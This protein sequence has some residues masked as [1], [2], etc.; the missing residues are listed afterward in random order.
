MKRPR[1]VRVYLCGSMEGRTYEAVFYEHYYVRNQLISMGFE[2][3]DPLLKESHKPGAK[4][5]LTKCGLNP[6]IVY[7]QDLEA[8]EKASIIF[9]VT[10][11]LPTEGSLTEIAWAGCMNRFKIGKHK[12]IVVVS[13]LRHSKKK[14]HFAN[15]HPG[16][17][18][19]KRIDDGLTFLKRK[20][21]RK[22][23]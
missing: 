15:M 2:V 11:D 3:F 9:W 22:G 18:V 6:K 1:I 17:K 19:V 20:F 10:G 12:D 5:G 7:K 4:I 16:V 21:K 23:V 13:P 8:V 14:N